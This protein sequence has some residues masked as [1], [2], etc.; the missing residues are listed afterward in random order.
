MRTYVLPFGIEISVFS[1]GNGVVERSNLGDEIDPDTADAIESL[2]LAL[3]C[4][5][6]DIAEKSFQ[7]AFESAIEAISNHEAEE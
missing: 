3:A 1:K 7:T 6:V 4:E 5:E 2:L